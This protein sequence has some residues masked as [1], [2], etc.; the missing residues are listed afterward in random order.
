MGMKKVPTE[1]E[2]EVEDQRGREE[3]EAEIEEG[4]R[5]RDLRRGKRKRFE[6]AKEKRKW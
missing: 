3:K 4:E 1:A 5:G 2:E 6:D